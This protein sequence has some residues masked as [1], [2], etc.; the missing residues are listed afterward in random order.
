MMAATN[1]ERY[2]PVMSS[3]AR[4]K[5]AAWSSKDIASHAGFAVRAASMAAFTW[6]V[7]C[8]RCVFGHC[9]AVLRG[10]QLSE[11]F[12]CSRLFDALEPSL[13]ISIVSP[14]GAPL[15]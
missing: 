14:T 1:S 4:R 13:W 6:L 9:F 7:R 3:H 15:T 8:S 2:L 12:L 5:I 10:V 11:K